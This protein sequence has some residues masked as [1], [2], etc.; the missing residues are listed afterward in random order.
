MTIS[1][2]TTALILAGG[3]GSRMGGCDKG[4]QLFRG[5]P[6]TGHLVARL[7]PQVGNR[8]LI[9]CNRNLD[10]YRS[11]GFPC[12]SDDAAH[13]AGPL[14]GLLAGLQQVT[15]PYC[16]VTPCDTPL[17]PTDVVTR[18]QQGLEASRADLAVVHDGE[19]RQVLHCLLRTELREQLQAWLQNGKRA[20]HAWQADCNTCEV[21]FADCAGAFRNLNSMAELQDCENQLKANPE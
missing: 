7:A 19:R 10:E 21:S 14:A 20:A 4:L 3:T 2:H 1:S 15:T 9:N 11:F 16:F 5:Q 8:L 12:I 17:L 6:L 13:G 18:L